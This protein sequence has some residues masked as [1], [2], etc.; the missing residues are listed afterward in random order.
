MRRNEEIIFVRRK[1]AV[2]LFSEFMIN[3]MFV[4][5]F[6]FIRWC[7]RKIRDKRY[8]IDFSDYSDGYDEEEDFLMENVLDRA[9]VFAHRPVT[10]GLGGQSPATCMK[11]WPSGFT[12]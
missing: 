4:W 12:I 7:I 5:P 3:F 10:T 9:I 8:D 1:S 11:D 2:M 6:K